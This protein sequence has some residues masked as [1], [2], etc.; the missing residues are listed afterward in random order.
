LFKIAYFL[1]VNQLCALPEKCKDGVGIPMATILVVDDDRTILTLCQ[2]TLRWGGHSV[3]SAQGG[4]DAI[5]LLQASAITIDLALLDIIMPGT[6]GIQL[7]SRIKAT[8]PNVPI[9][10]MTGY[11]FRE[12]QQVVGE[13]NP[14]RIIWKPF[15]PDALLRMI[16]NALETRRAASA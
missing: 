7:A 3:L 10:L 12:I 16:D 11:S 1:H 13:K 6:N 5:R 2:K 14:F 4:E 9:I 15:I 8:N